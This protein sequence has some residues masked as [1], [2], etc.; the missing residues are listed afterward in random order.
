MLHFCVMIFLNTTS[1]AGAS[2]VVRF[3]EV[4]IDNG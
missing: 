4:E 1:V 2:E 3:W